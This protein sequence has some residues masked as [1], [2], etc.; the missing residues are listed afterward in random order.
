MAFVIGADQL[1]D[2]DRWHRHEDLLSMCH[3]IVLGRGTKGMALSRKILKEWE[4][5]GIA[6]PRSGSREKRENV[7]EW[8]LTPG[9][10]F[11]G[12]RTLALVATEAPDISST[13]IRELVETGKKSSDSLLFPAVGRYLMQHE[14]YGSKGP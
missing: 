9:E 13:Q 1:A 14:L 4:E 12:K 8:F 11:T 10:K 2:F 3:W 5:R 7:Q 6:R